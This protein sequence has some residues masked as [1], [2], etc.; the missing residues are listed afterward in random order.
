MLVSDAVLAHLADLKEKCELWHKPQASQF[1]SEEEQ[2]EIIKVYPPS[3]YIRYDGGYENAR[4]KKVIFLFAEGDDFSDITC[5]K[6]SIDQRFREI[7]HRDILGA[8]MSLQIDRG[9]FGDFWIENNIIYLYTSKDM[10]RFLIDNL[11][12]INQLSVK[13]EETSEK[14]AQV[15][16][17]KDIEIIVAS[18]R[19]DA[20]VAGITHLSRSKAKELITSGLVQINHMT[21][22]EGEELCH[23]NNIVSIRGY[24]RF[25]YV[26]VKKTTKHDR[27]LILLKQSI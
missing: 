5:L 4:K 17:Y 23:N 2:A 12:R 8:L 20:I 15:F 7:G 27:K 14:P 18:E 1:F 24:G 3:K 26:G 9:S 22:E 10:S 16:K 25:V 11:L 13:F 21:V 19:L 6:A